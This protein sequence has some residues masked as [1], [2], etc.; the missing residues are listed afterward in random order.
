MISGKEI[1]QV[2]SF[3][4]F[5][6]SVEVGNV[7]ERTPRR[8]HKKLLQK[9]PADG[10]ASSAPNDFAKSTYVAEIETRQEKM[11][12]LITHVSFVHW[13]EAHDSNSK[14]CRGGEEEGIE[15][16]EHSTLPKIGHFIQV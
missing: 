13:W 9:I 16:K 2:S 15:E 5:K 8:L 11:R 6:I 1:H 7:S 3:K 12:K 14:H 10:G 4:Y